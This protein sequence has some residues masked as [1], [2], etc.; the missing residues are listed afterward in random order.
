M[1]HPSIQREVESN[2]TF[3]QDVNASTPSSALTAPRT[4]TML[5]LLMIIN[6]INLVDRNMFGLLLPEIKREVLLSDAELGL[7]G[8]PAFALT[9]AL[10]GIPIA[11]IADRFSRRNLIAAGVTFWSAAIAATGKATDALGLFG[12][13][14]VLGIGQASNMAPSSSLIADLFPNRSRTI[15]VSVYTSGGPLGIMLGFPFIG[16]MAQ[17]HGWRAAFLAMGLLGFAVALLLLLIGRE[18][19][20]A[21]HQQAR[22]TG[23]TVPF[24][25]SLTLLA[26]STPFVLLVMAGVCLSVTNTVMNVWAPTFLTRVHHLNLRETGD[27][28]GLYRGFLGVFAA[29]LGGVLVSRLT[30]RDP[31][32]VAWAPAILCLLMVPAELLFLWSDSGAG[33]QAG[34]IADTI[35]MSAATPC[36]FALLL[37]IVDSRIRAFGAAVYLLIFSL[38]GQS[39]GSVAVGLLNDWLA[40]E[41]REGAIRISMTLSPWA[42]GMTGILLFILS[43]KLAP[44]D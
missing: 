40:P 19:L 25:A 18:P 16:W 44:A 1:S 11:M 34:L 5:I 31:R 2:R 39:I 7:L 26:R 43:R 30:H 33:W 38:V 28:L 27:L 14:M 21:H 17:A 4:Y 12:A 9:Y 35:L 37:L 6:G 10:S 8:G 20:R 32:W 22:Q 41:F 29:I 15:A 36:T 23:N 13:R 24:V 3:M 42:I